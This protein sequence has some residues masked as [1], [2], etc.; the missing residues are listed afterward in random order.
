ML[1]GS[2]LFIA[3]A[4]WTNNFQ[5]AFLRVFNLPL[6][7]GQSIRL[8]VPTRER[9]SPD[10]DFV[11]RA[12]Y[13]RVRNYCATLEAKL[14]RER[15]RIETLTGLPE[16]SFLGNA[17][18]VEAIVYPPSME[19]K[20]NGEI[21]I[22]PDSNAKLT[23]G[24]FV[25]AENSIIGTISDVSSVG[26]RVEL[27]T[28][29]KS[30]IAV[31]IDGIKRYMQGEGGNLARIP[32]MTRKQKVGAEIMAARKAG[33]LGT[34]IIVGRVVRCEVNAQSAALCDLIVEPAFDID[35]LDDVIVLVMKGGK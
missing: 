15:E 4:R 20:V 34:P 25:L 12:E 33:V 3:P 30:N 5:F 28:S 18:L 27:I 35:S 14:V 23:Q 31:E 7:I 13:N 17:H 32:M 24:Q 26:I 2:I 16:K 1:G 8:S 19:D 22:Y 11:P 9:V 29:P 6:T 10:G 21:S